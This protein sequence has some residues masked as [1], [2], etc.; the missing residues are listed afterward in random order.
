MSKLMSYTSIDEAANARNIEQMIN[1]I[2]MAA[3]FGL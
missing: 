2:A 1:A 3:M